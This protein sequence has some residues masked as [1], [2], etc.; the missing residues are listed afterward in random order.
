MKTFYRPS[1]M[2][3]LLLLPI[4]ISGQVGREH[5]PLLV[6]NWPA[7][8]YWQPTRAEARAISREPDAG[9][10]SPE[11]TAPPN[12]LVF[13]A[14]TPCRVVDTRTGAGFTGNF[15]PPSLVGAASRTFPIQSST[16]C[17]IPAIAQAYSFNVTVVPPGVLGFVTVYPTGATLPNAS[18][19][20]SLQGFIVANAAIVP[21]GTSGSVDVFASNATDLIIDINGYYAPETG[22]T[23]A[24][25]TAGAPSLSFSADVGTGIFSSGTGMLNF[26]SGGTSR[27]TV[28]SDG[29]LDISGSIRKNGT[30][31]LHNLGNLNTGVGFGA[32]AANTGSGNTATGHQALF[33]NTVGAQNSASGHQALFNNTAGNGNTATGYGTLFRNT[34]GS[35]NTANG[36]LALSSNVSGVGNTAVGLQALFNSTASQNTA[37]GDLALYANVTGTHNTATGYEA[38]YNNTADDNTASG[39]L[40]L[41][42]NTTGA[43]NTASGYLALTSS[44]GSDNTAFGKSAPQANAVGDHNTGVGSQSLQFTT[45]GNNIGIGWLAGINVLSGSNNIMIGNVGSLSDS[46]TIRIGDTS[47]PQQTRAFLAGVRGVQTGSSGAV[48]VLIDPNGQLGTTNSSRRFKD[49]IQDMGEASSRLMQLRPVTYRYQQP[50]LDGSKP[51]DYGLIAEE[52]SAVYPDLVVNNADGQVETVQYQK[53]TPMLLN[54]IQKQHRQIQ[55]TNL[56]LMQDRQQLQEEIRQLKATLTDLMHQKLKHGRP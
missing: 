51:L 38:L 33:N 50:Y 24:P 6:T 26:S 18:T 8:L 36:T 11:A 30:L 29:D 16:R 35:E 49:D 9:I 55:A 3:L 45:G 14:I 56:Q 20:N 41:F 25:G 19:L 2:F 31:F 17:T 21:A 47:I 53:L 32:L 42:S 15:G 44:N 12:S 34:T 4:A 52:V 46:G 28:R 5:D 10:P 23:L 48:P 27:L 54:E 22:L 40:T 1:T 43:R 13:V 7:P 37:L 39:V